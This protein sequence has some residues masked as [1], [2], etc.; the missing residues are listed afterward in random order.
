MDRDEWLA[1]DQDV[2]KKGEMTRVRVR[3]W[4][5]NRKGT[6]QPGPYWLGLS[7]FGRG[8]GGWLNWV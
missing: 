4:G 6:A 5:G 1:W 8:E 2:H 3:K 7:F